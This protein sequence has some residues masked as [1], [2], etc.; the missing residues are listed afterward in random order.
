M[1]KLRLKNIYNLVNYQINNKNL[2]LKTGKFGI[3]KNS[4][5]PFNKLKISKVKIKAKAI[6][7]KIV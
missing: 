3:N 1:Q 7:N 2:L 6:K 4:N 5:K